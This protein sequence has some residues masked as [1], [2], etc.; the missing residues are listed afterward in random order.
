MNE[1]Q[2][3]D[4]VKVIHDIEGDVGSPY[5]GRYGSVF[6]V[7]EDHIEVEIDGDDGASYF[8]REELRLINGPLPTLEQVLA[9]LRRRVEAVAY[10]PEELEMM[11]RQR[12]G[13]VAVIDLIENWGER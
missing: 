9:V 10:S 11:E 7:T 6:N 13:I 3:G 1:L 12:P 4:R 5:L 2:A 8:A